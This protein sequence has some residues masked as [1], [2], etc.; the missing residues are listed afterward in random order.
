MNIVFGIGITVILVIFV[1]YPVL[2]FIDHILF[3]HN[4]EDRVA[5]YRMFAAKLALTEYLMIRVIN[6][7]RAQLGMSPI[8]EQ[9]VI[10]QF[11]GMGPWTSI[12]VRANALLADAL[13]NIKA[14]KIGK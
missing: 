3:S 9:A 8:P 10:D 7:E 11:K 2:Q 6:E 14:I 5:E 12:K 1:F 13:R 4:M